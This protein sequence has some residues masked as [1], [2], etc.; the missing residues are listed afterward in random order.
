MDDKGVAEDKTRF[1]GQEAIKQRRGDTLKGP[2]PLGAQQ[3]PVRPHP[4]ACCRWWP[5]QRKRADPLGPFL[6]GNV[7][8]L[9]LFVW[10]CSVALHCLYPDAI[11]AAD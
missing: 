3:D 6:F 7:P 9:L 4:V 10:L 8:V 5:R 2:G 11:V 1:I